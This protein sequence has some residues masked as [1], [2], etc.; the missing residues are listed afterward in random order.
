MTVAEPIEALKLLPQDMLVVTFGACDN[1]A[2]EPE[3]REVFVSTLPMGDPH[4]T[5]ET[6]DGRLLGFQKSQ[7]DA[8]TVRVIAL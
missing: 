8:T 6:G 2:I 3:P 5:D 7:A 1:S 4:D